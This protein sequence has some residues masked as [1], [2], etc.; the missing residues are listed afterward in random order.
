[1]FTVPA[2][3][4]G[5]AAFTLL[6]I[7]LAVTILALMSMSIYRFV[8]SNMLAMRISADQNASEARYQGF[9]NLLTQQW[10]E[11]PAGVGA[12]VGEPFKQNN[13]S[14]DEITWVCGAGPGLL[15][16]YATGDFTVSLRVRP[17]AKAADKLEI[18]IARRARGRADSGDE[19]ESWVPL[20]TEVRSFE[21]RYFDPRLNSWVERWTDTATLPRLIRLSVGRPDRAVPWDAVIALGRTPL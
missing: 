6:E 5:R 16:R 11:L 9:L 10:G 19:A 14:R 18:G 15:T 20:L 8:Q 7:T 3:L 4:R 1:M 12:L 17:M 2:R 21:V 13:V